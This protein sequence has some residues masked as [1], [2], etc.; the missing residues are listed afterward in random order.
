MTPGGEYG[1]D[2][3]DY[4]GRLQMVTTPMIQNGFFP[5]WAK[6]DA[7]LEELERIRMFLSARQY[8]DEMP[9][10]DEWY[11]NYCKVGFF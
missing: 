5:N 10:S 7:Q 11:E 2:D 8:P 4:Y 6:G 9:L 1:D 3:D